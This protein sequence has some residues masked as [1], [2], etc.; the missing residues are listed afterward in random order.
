M[1]GFDVPGVRDSI[2]DGVT[3]LLARGE[4][5][6]AAAWCTLAL[7]TERRETFGKAAGERATSYRWANSVREFQ[8]VASEAIVTH[9]AAQGSA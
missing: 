5:S 3:G 8:A 6:F 9:Q 1:I 2:E 4:S 7:S